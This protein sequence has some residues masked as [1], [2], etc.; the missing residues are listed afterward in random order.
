MCLKQLGFM[1]IAATSLS[2]LAK[3]DAVE[4]G[5][6]PVEWRDDCNTWT[7]VEIKGIVADLKK[8]G[9]APFGYEASIVCGPQWMGD[10]DWQK[11]GSMDACKKKAQALADEKFAKAEAACKKL[12]QEASLKVKMERPIYE[13]DNIQGWR[14]DGKDRMKYVRKF[15]GECSK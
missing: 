13:S 10:K 11:M 5:S 15:G 12:C 2:S 7:D 3:G 1:I 6:Y 9:R 14:A 8:G 4:V